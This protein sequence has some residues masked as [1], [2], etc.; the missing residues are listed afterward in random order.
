[1]ISTQG[2]QAFLAKLRA[3]KKK[4]EGRVTSTHRN[5]VK[6]ILKELVEHSP[7]WSGNLASNWYLEFHGSIA[8]YQ[9][10]SEYDTMSFGRHM[11]PYVM[12]QDPAV[13]Q[14]LARENAK[15]PQIRWNTIV[16]IVNKAPY[17]EDVEMN[18]GPNGRPIRPENM[19]A[20]YG[21]VAMIGYVEAK[22]RNKSEL[23]KL[24]V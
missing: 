15:L 13:G 10:L 11:S 17:A 21:G 5:I 18:Q 24:I 20:S 9:E 23:K 8:T 12:G 14:T 4:L 3:D 7:Q 16:H 1:M 2:S 22:Y 19:L 6:T